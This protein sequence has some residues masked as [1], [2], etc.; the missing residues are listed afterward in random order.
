MVERDVEPVAGPAS[1]GELACADPVVDRAAADADALGDPGDG[2]LA[3]VRVAD[4]VGDLVSPA[5]L[6]YVIGRERAAAAGCEP[7][8]VELFGDLRIGVRAR[9]L[10]GQLDGLGRGA[11]DL[12]ACLRALERVLLAGA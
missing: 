11:N 6:L 8:R 10:A 1:G 4:G 9:E 3:V 2:Q 12:G 7:G 5:D